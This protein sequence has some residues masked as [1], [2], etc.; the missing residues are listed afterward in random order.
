MPGRQ[1]LGGGPGRHRRLPAGGKSCP[2][3][4][5]G[6]AFDASVQQW[7]A[8]TANRQARQAGIPGNGRRARKRSALPRGSRSSRD[9]TRNCARWENASQCHSPLPE[10]VSA[11]ANGIAHDSLGLSPSHSLSS[12]HSLD[13]AESSAPLPGRTCASGCPD[14]ARVRWARAA[15]HD[16]RVSHAAA[17]FCTGLGLDR[18]A[19]RPIAQA[20]QHV[21][22]RAP[23]TCD[24]CTEPLGWL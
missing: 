6:P 21:C 7:P 11:R 24:D 22:V 9:R 15:L 18:Q 16:V 17:V 12:G 8:G 4:R 3:G 20:A 19:G 23:S 1:P 10:P 5:S 14:S 13:S 2:A